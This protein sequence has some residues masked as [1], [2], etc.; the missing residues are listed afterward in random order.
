MKK[1]INQ[2]LLAMIVVAA[3]TMTVISC[4]DYQ[5]EVDALDKRVTILENLT[6]RVNT[7][8][9]ALQKIVDAMDKGDYI[10]NVTK[11][12]TGTI[13]TFA[14]HGAITILDGEPGDNAAIPN[15]TVE[16]DDADGNYYWKIDGNWL[17]D[18][19]GNRVRANGV[20]G[21]K[22]TTPE[23]MIDPE[24]GTWKYRL[25]DG[26]W[27]DTGV[28]AKGK[29]GDDAPGV[30]LDVDDSTKGEGY[31]TIVINN[32]GT[33]ERI[34]VPTQ[35][36][37]PVFVT[38]VKLTASGDITMHKGD[39]RLIEYT[40]EPINATYKDV[41]FYNK[42]YYSVNTGNTDAVTY[43]QG[44][45]GAWYIHANDICSVRMRVVARFAQSDN[46]YDEI[47]INVIP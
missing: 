19:N 1:I 10:T 27:Q 17:T 30:V 12:A 20:D 13:V 21:Q 9:N 22:G 14:K 40:V 28:A 31:V 18:D 43:E 5:D 33:P 32:N 23:V 7:N 16:K 11:T 39:M 35:E 36:A 47:N 41:F 6:N 25:G 38:S 42:I 4:T 8:L 34:K 45:D 15:I 37:M 2:L 44:K 26:P 46:V 3:G 24:T 29:D